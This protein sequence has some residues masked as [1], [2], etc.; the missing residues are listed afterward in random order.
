MTKPP[1]F[2]PAAAK[3]RLQQQREALAPPTAATHPARPLEGPRTAT[4]HLLLAPEE[5][6]LE[7]PYVRQHVDEEELDQLK[8]AVLAGGEIKQAVGVRTEGTPL[9]P[10]YVLVYGMRRWMASKAAGLARIPVRNHGRI[11]V[12]DSL[13]LQVTENEARV[14]PHPVDTAVSYQMLVQEA[15]MT[16][17]E[18]ARVAGR[19]AAHV[20]YMRAVGEAVLQLSA[21]E[22][23]ALYRSPDAT[24]PR[25][26][27]IAP[28]K[29]VEERVRALRELAGAVE[30]DEA[31]RVPPPARP[32]TFRAGNSKR[33]GSWQVR[34]SY[35]D[36][37]LRRDPELATRLERFLEEQLERVRAQRPADRAARGPITWEI[38][39]E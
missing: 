27:K 38:A 6:V 19:S 16:Q 7:G 9:E 37:E 5:I 10:R 22:R 18:V 36:E 15:G 14:D 26:Q 28:L 35:R 23:E 13:A 2:D 8:H 39:A 34:L 11:S 31:R 33:D 30:A 21:A 20:S 25:F 24:V 3:Q 4:D 29:T 32:A 1:R 12:A 17:A